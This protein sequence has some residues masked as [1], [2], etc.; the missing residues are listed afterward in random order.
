MIAQDASA[1]PAMDTQKSEHQARLGGR[2]YCRLRSVHPPTEHAIAT[3]L[4][5]STAAAFEPAA[6]DLANHP[7]L[8]L[9]T[10]W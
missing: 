4:R 10:F 5:R 3:E 6:S 2:A 7:R 8:D 1:C 9:L